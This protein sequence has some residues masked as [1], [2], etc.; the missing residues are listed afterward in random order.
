MSKP[1][2]HRPSGKRPRRP[3]PQPGDS[4]PEGLAE[5]CQ[6]RIFL[7]RHMNREVCRRKMRSM[8]RP[9]GEGHSWIVE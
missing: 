4:V 8:A 2:E 7:K 6:A 5:G 3:T 1:G 9:V